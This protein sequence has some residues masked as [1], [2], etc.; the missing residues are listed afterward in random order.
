MTAKT[1][2]KGWL[3]LSEQ[4]SFNFQTNQKLN[5]ILKQMFNNR[6]STVEPTYS[7][8]LELMVKLDFRQLTKNTLYKYTS[9]ACFILCSCPSDN[10]MGKRLIEI[11][12]SF[13]N[14]LFS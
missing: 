6:G 8:I 1:Y 12:F 11:V 7:Q 5:I 4:H 10:L 14:S 3:S 9:K 13:G 2:Q